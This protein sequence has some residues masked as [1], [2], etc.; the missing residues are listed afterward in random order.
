MKLLTDVNGKSEDSDIVDRR[1]KKLVDFGY[2][3]YEF[4]TS[5]GSILETAT[6]DPRFFLRSFCSKQIDKPILFQAPRRKM[7]VLF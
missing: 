7:I 3:L 1:L 6:G 2:N 5:H 4:M